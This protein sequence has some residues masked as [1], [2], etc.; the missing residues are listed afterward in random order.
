MLGKIWEEYEC[1]DPEEIK[2]FERQ[3]KLL[4]LLYASR[5]KYG[6]IFD[7][8]KAKFIDINTKLLIKCTIHSKDIWVS[9]YNH[10]EKFK[11]GGCN[12]CKEAG[13]KETISI[14]NKEKSE[15]KICEEV[16]YID[17]EEIK[18]FRRME[19]LLGLL[20]ASRKRFGKVFDF[21]RAT[22]ISKN[23]K[24]LLRCTLH[25]ENIWVT[26]YDHKKL[27][28]Y[29]GCRGCRNYGECVNALI[30]PSI[31]NHGNNFDFSRTVY[32]NINYSVCIRCIKHD[33]VFS[34]HISTHLKHKHGGCRFCKREQVGPINL[35]EGE[36]LRD[37]CLTN[38]KE[39]YC[40]SNFGRCFSKYSGKQL[41]NL[42]S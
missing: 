9:P 7:F 3:E 15:K 12:E 20:Y 17:P 14:K 35:M 4:E 28:K 33:N 21:S 6:K 38:Y 40:V 11:Y 24:L 5:K 31:K 26:P 22:Y 2:K 23:T 19:K 36:E 10:K 27:L 25:S 34:T 32:K 42:G 18:K 8:S 13:K 16:I 29:G 30:I 37:V 1:I 41:S 39:H